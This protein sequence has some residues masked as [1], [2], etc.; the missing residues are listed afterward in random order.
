MSSTTPPI[1]PGSNGYAS[2]PAISG[3]GTDPYNYDQAFTQSQ[4]ATAQTNQS[5]ANQTQQM[6]AYGQASGGGYPAMSN[7]Y[8]LGATP[9]T[10]VPGTQSNPNYM[11]NPNQTAVPDAS[12]RGF[13][14]WSLSV[15][16][17]LGAK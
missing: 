7:S 16:P 15:R 17:S 5:I 13:N 1:T 4:Q 14:P 9:Q 6:N 12:S 10:A 8:G 2:V 3:W 11:A